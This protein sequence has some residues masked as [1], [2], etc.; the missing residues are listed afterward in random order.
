MQHQ[1]RCRAL[2]GLLNGG[3]VAA[4]CKLENERVQ[5]V[6][7][8]QRKPM[9]TVFVEWTQYIHTSKQLESGLCGPNTYP[10]KSFIWLENV[11]EDL[12]FVALDLQAEIQ[13]RQSELSHLRSAELSGRMMSY[14]MSAV[15]IG[16]CLFDEEQTNEMHGQKSFK[17]TEQLKHKWRQMNKIEIT[18]QQACRGLR[19]CQTTEH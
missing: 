4:W 13:S 9:H 14:D 16:N 5:G 12:R 3:S 6:A 7:S 18:Y 11:R 19:N 17:T 8:C 2:E 15:W 10:V 1:L